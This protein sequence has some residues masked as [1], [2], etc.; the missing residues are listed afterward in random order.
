ATMA[1]PGQSLDAFRG[2]GI[3][4]TIS[5]A[6]VTQ[7]LIQLSVGA[8]RNRRGEVRTFLAGTVRPPSYRCAGGTL[9]PPVE[10]E[11]IENL[12]REVLDRLD[13]FGV[14]EVEILH[15]SS[16]ARSAVVEVDARPWLQFGLPFAC[17]LDLIRHAL[18]ESAR[19]QRRRGTHAWI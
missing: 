10:V 18:D 9:V 3:A 5:E 1:E 13:Y 8:A 17:G 11:G 4:A 15:D 16:T 2:A 6:L 7:T 14:A 19:H 12:A